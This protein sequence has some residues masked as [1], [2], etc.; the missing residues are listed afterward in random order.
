MTDLP[1]EHPLPHPEL[2]G[3]SSPYW[4]VLD[5]CCKC[6]IARNSMIAL[7]AGVDLNHR[8]LGYESKSVP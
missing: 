7:V 5:S 4:T 6:P 8:P 1:G 3:G 2:Q